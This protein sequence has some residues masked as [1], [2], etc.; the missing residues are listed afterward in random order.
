MA[1]IT[2]INCLFKVDYLETNELRDEF[3]ESYLPV[4]RLLN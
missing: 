4:N 2:S 1:D 3:F